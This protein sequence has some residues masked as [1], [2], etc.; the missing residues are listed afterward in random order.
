MLSVAKGEVNKRPSRQLLQ[1]DPAFAHFEYLTELDL[2]RNRLR[3]LENLPEGIVSLSCAANELSG[4][5]CGGTA[6]R[7][8][9]P[10]RSRTFSSRN[11]R[12][13]STAVELR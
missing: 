6:H 5:M 11:S 9:R 12:C 10:Q 3:K 7:K 1:I 2:G 8:R 4:E 13:S